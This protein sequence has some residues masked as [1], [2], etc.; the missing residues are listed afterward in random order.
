MFQAAFS[1]GDSMLSKTKHL[2]PGSLRLTVWQQVTDFNQTASQILNPQSQ[3]C[4]SWVDP[5]SSI[6]P[7]AL[8]THPSQCPS[9]CFAQDLACA[10]A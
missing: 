8:G 7:W 1:T 4:S 5:V 3:P 6:W 10:K 2:S 9:R